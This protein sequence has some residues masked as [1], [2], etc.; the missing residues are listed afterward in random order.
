M[1]SRNPGR[2]TGWPTHLLAVVRVLYFAFVC[3]RMR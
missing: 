1:K 3:S 2:E